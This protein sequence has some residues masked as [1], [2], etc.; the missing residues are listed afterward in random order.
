MIHIKEKLFH[1]AIRASNIL[2]T[3]SNHVFLSDFANYKPLF[4]DEEN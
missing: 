2:L 3:T 1:G 4:I